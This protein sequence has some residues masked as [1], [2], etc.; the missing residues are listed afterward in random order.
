MGGFNLVEQRKKGSKKNDLNFHNSSVC[1]CED[2]E[3][4]S[5]LNE[6]RLKFTNN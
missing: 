3:V 4:R 6:T 1:K 2:S 5:G